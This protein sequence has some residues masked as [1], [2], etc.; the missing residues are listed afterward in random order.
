M[1]SQG[2]ILT[3]LQKNMGRTWAANPFP[4]HVKGVIP[5]SAGLTS[6]LQTVD[7]Y[8]AW[9]PVMAGLNPNAGISNPCSGLPPPIMAKADSL[10]DCIYIK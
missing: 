9:N 3:I 8:L 6:A 2:P 1:T 7:I 4:R 5:S 10:K